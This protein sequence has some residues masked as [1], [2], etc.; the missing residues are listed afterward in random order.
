MVILSL[1]N[2]KEKKTYDIYIIHSELD[3]DDVDY[4]KKSVSEEE[5]IKDIKVDDSLFENAPI[6]HSDF[7]K[8]GYYKLL[9]PF[10]LP[11][12]IKK[13]LYLDCD[14][15]VTKDLSTMY[16]TDLKDMYYAAVPDRMINVKK[17]KYVEDLGIAKG[18]KYYNTGVLLINVEKIRKE[19]EYDYYKDYI[20]SQGSKFQYHDQ[21]VIN[22]FHNRKILPLSNEFNYPATAYGVVDFI[23]HII[24]YKIPCVVHYSGVKPWYSYYYGFYYPLFLKHAEGLIPIDRTHEG[25]NGHYILKKVIGV[26]NFFRRKLIKR[27]TIIASS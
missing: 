10:V 5:R 7:S 15:I 8:E 22:Y 24:E 19:V 14:I 17:R 9:L 26:V 18:D 1:Y 23:N 27:R 12:H 11:A 16:D 25:K 20:N 2:V 13:A 21:Q 4:I 6:I 3:K